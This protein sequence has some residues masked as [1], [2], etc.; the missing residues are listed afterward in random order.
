MAI[1]IGDAILKLKIDT[2]D[3]DKGFIGLRSTIEQHRK[4]IGIA[5]L[6]MATA[7]IGGAIASVKAYADMGSAV[8]DMS[9]RTGFST[10]SL[11]ELK[12]AAEQTG[13]SLGGLEVGIRRMSSVIVD[14]STGTNASSKAIELLGFTVQD[15]KGMKP[16]DQF[17]KIALALASIKDPTLKSA[18]AVDI[19]GRSGTDLLPL[20]A[21]GADG[22][23]RLRKEAHDLGIVF[24][25]E[26]AASADRLG[27]DLNKLNK[28]IEGLKFTVAKELAPSVEYLIPLLSGWA[29]ALG[30]I[31]ENTLNWYA[32]E[33]KAIAMQKAWR[34]VM[35]ERQKAMGGLANDYEGVVNS[36]ENMLKKQGLWNEQSEKTVAKLRQE[37]QERGFHKTSI[38]DETASLE[39]QNTQRDET[40]E[41]IEKQVAAYQSLQEEVEKTRQQFDYENSEAGRLG[42]TLKDVTYT[43]FGLGYSNDEVTKKLS[44]LGSE[45]DNV[46]AV[47]KAFGLTTEAVNGFLLEHNKALDA[48]SAAYEKQADAA[49][50][51]AYQIAKAARA[52]G[53]TGTSTGFGAGNIEPGMSP[54]QVAFAL[55]YNFE[56]LTPAQYAEISGITGVKNF[57]YGGLITEPTLLTRLGSSIPY[58][59]MAEKGPERITPTGQQMMTLILMMDG[60]QMA[61]TIMPYAVGEIRLKGALKI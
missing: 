49:A 27:D 21:E 4:A 17:M 19:F 52:A 7:V 44:Q 3:F 2:A 42:I 56:K 43:L 5:M 60:K 11:S 12:Y 41:I 10:E 24:D 32:A 40:T 9:K 23:S 28:Q 46:N 55:G 22:I 14:A 13:T 59:I 58:G 1:S 15:L 51:A 37:I 25:E 8:Y 53:F 61:R 50:E 33:D 54:Y 39:E 34:S 31:I 30:P 48:S 18:T 57:Q 26:A 38:E 29:K 20:L 35:L 47:M 6:G 16:E 36:L 45:S